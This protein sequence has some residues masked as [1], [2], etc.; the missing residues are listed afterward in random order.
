MLSSIPSLPQILLQLCGGSFV[1]MPTDYAL[2]V[3]LSMIIMLFDHVLMESVSLCFLR[4]YSE[5]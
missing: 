4:M 1:Q 2:Q 5:G 3:Y